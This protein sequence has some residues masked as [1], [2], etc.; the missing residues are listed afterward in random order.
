MEIFR[1]LVLVEKRVAF[2]VL[3]ILVFGS[4]VFFTSRSF[5][6]ATVSVQQGTTS[7]EQGILNF[8]LGVTSDSGELVCNPWSGSDNFVSCL[9]GVEIAETISIDLQINNISIFNDEIYLIVETGKVLK[10]EG[11]GY[12]EFLNIEDKV[13][14]KDGGE[15]D[16]LI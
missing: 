16:F 14:Y 5:D 15:E 11:E 13:L 10:V 9:Y 2:S 7:N 3:T 6:S 4:I 8:D 12:S 1:N